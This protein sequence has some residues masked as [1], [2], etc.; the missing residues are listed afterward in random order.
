MEG[1]N[2]L[3]FDCLNK[4]I[5]H[6]QF[7]AQEP[8]GGVFLYD[9][10]ICDERDRTPF[11]YPMVMDVGFNLRELETGQGA[12]QRCVSLSSRVSVCCFEQIMCRNL[13]AAANFLP[14]ILCRHELTEDINQN[15]SVKDVRAAFFSRRGDL[16]FHIAL[17]I[18]ERGHVFFHRQREQR[19]LHRGPVTFR[20][21]IKYVA[22]KQ[23]R[24]RVSFR[25]KGSALFWS[26][27]YSILYT[28]FF[29]S[30]PTR[31][32][33]SSILYTPAG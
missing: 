33:G 16:H 5:S 10:R 15:V 30:L 12:A 1:Q 29:D 7:D 25:Q 20:S 19:M 8:S 22:H 27:H 28:P 3:V 31:A 2:I 26:C 18:L 11:T 6:F 21:C 23:I 32:S 9:T 4:P 14:V 24:F 17:L 13:H